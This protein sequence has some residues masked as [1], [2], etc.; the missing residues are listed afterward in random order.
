M[1]TACVTFSVSSL[2]DLHLSLRCWRKVHNNSIEFD[3]LSYEISPTKRKSVCVLF[4]PLQSF[5][6]LESPPSSL[7]PAILTSFTL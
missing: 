6:V 7:W 4:H 2:L 5:C 1:R 3:G